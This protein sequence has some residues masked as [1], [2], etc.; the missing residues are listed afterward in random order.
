[1]ENKFLEDLEK[2]GVKTPI[3]YMMVGEDSYFDVYYSN[4]EEVNDKFNTKFKDFDEAWEF[5]SKKGFGDIKQIHHEWRD[6]DS[7]WIV[8]ECEKY[9]EFYGAHVGYSSY[10]GYDYEY[11]TLKRVFPKEKTIVV[12]E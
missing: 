7:A 8:W 1:M 10:E 3:M 11:V 2:S 9:G 4:I 5:I 12:Y 6:T